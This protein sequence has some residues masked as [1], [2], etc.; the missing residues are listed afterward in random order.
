[1]SAGP[2]PSSYDARA[3][4][5]PCV[6]LPSADQLA[7][8]QRAIRFAAMP[9]AV[10]KRPPTYRAGPLPSSK[11]ESEYPIGYGPLVGSASPL[12]SADQLSPSHFAMLFAGVP[13]AAKN[14]PAA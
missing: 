3:S 10:S 2:L 4:G 14:R 11:V 6:P 12:P 13:P 8:S 5:D 9:P 1:M 7:P